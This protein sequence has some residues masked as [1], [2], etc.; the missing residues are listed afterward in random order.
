MKNKKSAIMTA[1]MTA[2]DKEKI[3]RKAAQAGMTVTDYL[4]I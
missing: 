3:Q 2:A 1:R 4:T